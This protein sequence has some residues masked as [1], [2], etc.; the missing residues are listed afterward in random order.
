VQRGVYETSINTI[1]AY[2]PLCVICIEEI[3][4]KRVTSTTT[5]SSHAR[6]FLCLAIEAPM[7]SVD[8]HAIVTTA[9]TDTTLMYKHCGTSCAAYGN[10]DCCCSSAVARY[11]CTAEFTSLLHG[12]RCLSLQ[13]PTP[14]CYIRSSKS[15]SI[16]MN[17]RKKEKNTRS[18]V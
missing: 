3:L 7:H 15:T 18:A 2:A 17:G 16:M 8:S 6:C 9:E 1:T 12:C 11:S 14:L 13:V 5:A 4:L 10:I